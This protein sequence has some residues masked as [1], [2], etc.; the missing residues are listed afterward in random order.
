MK[1]LSA[2]GNRN[3]GIEQRRSKRENTYLPPNL[4]VSMPMGKRITDPVR[5]GIPKSHPTWTISHLKIPLSTKKVTRTPLRVQQAKHT[6]KAKVFKN[7]IRCD[8]E[9]EFVAD[10][11]LIIFYT[12]LSS[13]SYLKTAK[14][15]FFENN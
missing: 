11:I 1:K 5:I 3:K 9:R 13:M 2:K 14:T 12:K 8:S 6:V 10:I 15:Q 4:S 7:R